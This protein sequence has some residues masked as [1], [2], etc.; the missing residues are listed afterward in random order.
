MKLYIAGFLFMLTAWSVNA[1]S[2]ADEVQIISEDCGCLFGHRLSQR[3]YQYK[4]KQ[5]HMTIPRSTDSLSMKIVDMRSKTS[6]IVYINE[7]HTFIHSFGMIRADQNRIF[8]GCG[9]KRL[10]FNVFVVNYASDEITRF[11]L[12]RIPRYQSEAALFSWCTTYC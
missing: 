12:G 9:G 6:E 8:F 3:A 1:A 7:P 2:P 10:N 4:H 5:Y 11:F